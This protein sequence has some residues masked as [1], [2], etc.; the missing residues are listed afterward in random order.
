[1]TTVLNDLQI[2]SAD[3][4][5]EEI[6]NEIAASVLIPDETADQILSAGVPQANDVAA[7]YDATRASR[8]SCCVA[9]TR[10]LSGPGC[11]ILGTPDGT[12]VFAAHHPSTPWRIARGTPQGRGSLLVSA[13]LRQSARARGVTRVQFASGTT[14]GD[15]H[16]DAF[17][18]DDGW[19][20]QVVVADTHSPWQQGLSVGLTDTGPDAEEIECG[21]CDEASLVRAAPCRNCGDRTCP[22]CGYCSCRAGAAPRI[23]HSCF[24][25]K[26][27]VEF[28]G[29]AVICID[30][31]QMMPHSGV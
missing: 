18:A 31:A 22:K 10:R 14:S 11:V 17:A 13:A 12:A 6:C 30:C 21:R 3:R 26:A 27:P 4:R 19:V 1:M 9:A 5:D 2:D 20:Y 7:L 29:T 24:L 23:C 25:E 15:V 8:E 28:A 16:S